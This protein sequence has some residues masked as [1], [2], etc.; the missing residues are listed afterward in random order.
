MHV[1]V[2]HG[3]ACTLLHH[4]SVWFSNITMETEWPV[5]TSDISAICSSC[6]RCQWGIIKHDRSF[7]DH[8]T[9]REEWVHQLHCKS[10]YLTC[11]VINKNVQVTFIHTISFCLSSI[12]FCLSSISSSLS[13]ICF[14]RIC[15]SS[16]VQMPMR[17]IK[18]D[19]SFTVHCM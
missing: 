7:T 15:S 17:I 9:Q 12:R 10:A 4:W 1:K 3:R 18:H 5:L 19:C 11:T 13:S 16:C 14:S 8:Y 2:E 6:V